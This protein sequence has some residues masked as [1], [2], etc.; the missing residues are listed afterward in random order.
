MPAFKD[1]VIQII[2]TPRGGLLLFTAQLTE[3]F[4]PQLFLE[5]PEVKRNVTCRSNYNAVIYNPL[6]SHRLRSSP[7]DY[8]VSAE[9]VEK[10]AAQTYTRRSAALFSSDSPT[11]HRKPSEKLAAAFFNWKDGLRLHCFVGM[12]P[13]TPS[14]SPHAAL[15]SD[16]L[17]GCHET[18][19]VVMTGWEPHQ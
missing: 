19:S 14:L 8:S 9:A 1:H 18:P 17:Q 13:G 7:S 11:E 4:R 6:H 3:G 10:P 12:L 2:I 15:A 16:C 5:F